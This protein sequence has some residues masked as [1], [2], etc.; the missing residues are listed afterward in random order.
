M[1]SPNSMTFAVIMKM[2]SSTNTT[3]TSGT[4]LIS[5][6]A[7]GAPNRRP[8]CPPLLKEKATLSAEIPLREVLKLDGEVFHARAHFFDAR[9]EHVIENGGRNCRR[10]SNSRR[11]QR[12]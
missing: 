8:R 2:T 11:H 5:D 3:S 9:S 10:K 1:S 4:T 7:E 12:F 6:M